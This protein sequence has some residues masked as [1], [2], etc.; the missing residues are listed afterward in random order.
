MEALWQL[1]LII[2]LILEVLRNKEIIH[3]LEDP[4]NAKHQ[5]S[6]NEQIQTKSHASFFMLKI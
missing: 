2:I 3:A 6:S 5:N 4:H 1:I